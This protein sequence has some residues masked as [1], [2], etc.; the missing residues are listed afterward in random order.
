MNPISH[1]HYKIDCKYSVKI[2]NSDTHNKIMNTIPLPDE[3]VRVIYSYI[4]PAFEY[5]KYIKNVRG[6]SETRQELC[7]LCDECQTVSYRGS[8]EDKLDNCVNIAS[9]SCLASEYLESIGSFIDDN[10]KFKRDGIISNYKYKT[11]FD[12]EMNEEKIEMIES[13]MSFRRGMWVYPD[14]IMEVLLFHGIPETLFHGSIKD[15]MYS[16]IINNIRG[17]KIAL[18]KYQRRNKIYHLSERD[19]SKFVNEYYNNLDWNKV[20]VVA[21]RKGLI[22]KLMKI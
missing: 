19:I 5:S 7:N 1:L 10:P 4:N 6:Y 22:R 9:Y 14:E 12:Y 13:D 18:G 11:Q 16:C 20:D 17:F 3:L 2:N 21:Y 15:I 8:A